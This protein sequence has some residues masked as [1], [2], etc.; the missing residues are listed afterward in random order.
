MRYLPDWLSLSK[1]RDLLVEAGQH[2]PLEAE[3]DICLAL[4][5]RKL[6]LRWTLE[7]VTYAPNG[8]TLSPAYALAL[9]FRE[10]IKLKLAVPAD[11]K[12]AGIDW[13]NSRPLRPWPYGPWQHQ[14]LAHVA[15][16]EISKADFEREFSLKAGAPLPSA[17][18]LPP[19]EAKGEAGEGEVDFATIR[20]DG[21]RI[22]ASPP[23]RDRPRGKWTLRAIDELWPNGVPDVDEL[24][25]GALIDA[26]I[27]LAKRKGWNV[28]GRDTILRMA[29]RRRK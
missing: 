10:V 4:R 25:N 20:P 26:V 11:I 14:L 12:S 27:E 13:D 5:D 8:A 21:A 24:P 22:E 18:T 2:S 28:G 6:R 7:K 29:G 19:A 15:K 16:L 17:P 1:S 9:E 3:T 23:C